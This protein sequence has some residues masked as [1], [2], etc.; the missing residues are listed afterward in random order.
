MQLF[1]IKLDALRESQGSHNTPMSLPEVWE[2]F[3]NSA[4]MDSAKNMAAH[5]HHFNVSAFGQTIEE[6]P[7]L[8]GEEMSS[9]RESGGGLED[10]D[11]E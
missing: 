2:R 8:L 4:D 1:K 11:T 10:D 5:I 6:I 9:M 7:Q 3:G